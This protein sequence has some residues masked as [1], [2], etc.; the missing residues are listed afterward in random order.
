MYSER[1]LIDCKVCGGQF[2]GV[3]EVKNDCCLIV[4]YCFT[5]H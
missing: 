5:V 3:W 4:K 2:L 1:V